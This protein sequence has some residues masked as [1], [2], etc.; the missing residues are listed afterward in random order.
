MSSWCQSHLRRN[1]PG[2]QT[3][4]L[5]RPL[6]QFSLAE[7]ALFSTLQAAQTWLHLAHAEASDAEN[8]LVE[9]RMSY[10]E[11][12]EKIGPCSQAIGALKAAHWRVWD[13][14]AYFVDYLYV[15][16][17]K[18]ENNLAPFQSATAAE[19]SEVSMTVSSLSSLFYGKP[20]K[21]NTYLGNQPTNHSADCSLEHRRLRANLRI[22][23]PFHKTLC[24]TDH[25]WCTFCLP[26]CRLHYENTH[27]SDSLYVH[28]LDAVHVCAVHR[29][30]WC[31]SHLSRVAL[32]TPI[33]KRGFLTN[34]ATMQ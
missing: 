30:R 6:Q 19:T 20:G 7:Q 24:S 28:T 13:S 29:N 12:D 14:N 21:Q 5:H 10:S 4:R 27:Q 9:S 17:A 33:F 26:V 2:A 31:V 15:G 32:F 25:F 11:W 22:C 23:H 3:P 34:L 8:S 16:R 18:H 1:I